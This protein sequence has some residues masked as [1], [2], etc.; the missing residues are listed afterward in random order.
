MLNMNLYSAEIASEES[1]YEDKRVEKLRG[2]L[3]R[4]DT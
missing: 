2:L 4:M 1:M 3:Q